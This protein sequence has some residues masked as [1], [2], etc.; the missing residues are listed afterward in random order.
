MTTGMSETIGTDALQ[1]VTTLLPLVLFAA[2]LACALPRRAASTVLTLTGV[3][4]LLGWFPGALPGLDE[5]EWAPGALA[6]ALGNWTGIAG[7][8]LVPIAALVLAGTAASIL[9]NVKA[10]LGDGPNPVRLKLRAWGVPVLLVSVSALLWSTMVLG[11][12]F[13]FGFTYSEVEDDGLVHVPS[14][15][16]DAAQAAV[17]LA[18][19]LLA[20]AITVG[21]MV[22]GRRDATRP[23]LIAVAIAVVLGLWTLWVPADVRDFV[24]V[25]D[26]PALTA[27]AREIGDLGGATWWWAIVLPLAVHAVLASIRKEK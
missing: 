18:P 8:L 15:G 3:T 9:A 23:I 11:D 17:D 27:F 4:F 19:G 12:V 5:R 2:L 14:T 24:P 20:V 22:R 1:R 6:H 7:F 26:N 10:R 21:L 16:R 13:G 25:L